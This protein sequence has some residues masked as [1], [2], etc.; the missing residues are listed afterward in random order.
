MSRDRFEDVGRAIRAAYAA[1]RATGTTAA[2]RDV[3]A[4][5]V[6]LVSSYSRLT[7]RV[8]VA[9]L[10]ESA[11]R[12]PKTVRASLVRLAS[13]GV[14]VYEGG[15]GRGRRSLVGL[16]AALEGE[17]P[18]TPL[19]AAQEGERLAAPLLLERG[20]T[21]NRKGSA[22]GLPTREGARGET[23]AAVAHAHGPAGARGPAADEEP[24]EASTLIAKVEAA[25]PWPL[26]DKQRATLRAAWRE[27]PDGVARELEDVLADRTVNSP[28]A[29]LLSRIH[30]GGHRIERKPKRNEFAC[31]HCGRV[32]VSTFE[33][34]EHE[35]TCTVDEYALR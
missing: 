1:A 18:E 22:Q 16:P 25:S 13:Q 24:A 2:D 3:I 31:P 4:A 5:V 15:N 12:H 33:R 35:A 30:D 23:P 32:F 29:V 17:R 28:C 34:R 7:D 11:A 9:R 6:E 14:L 10:A 27:S 21:R 20:A 8:S 19:S 26:T